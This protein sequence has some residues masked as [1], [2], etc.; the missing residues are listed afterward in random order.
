MAKNPAPFTHAKQVGFNLEDVIL[1]TNNKVALLYPEHSNKELFLCVSDFISKYGEEVSAKGTL[2]KSLLPPR[3]K[4]L[5]AQIIQCLGGKTGGFNQITNK[6]AIILYCLANGFNI[7]YAM[8]LWEDIINK[9]KKKNTEKFVNNWALKPNQTEGPPFIDHMMEICNAE[10]PVAFKAPKPSSNAERVPQGTKPGAKPGHKKHSTSKQPPVSSSEVNKGGSSKAST[11]SKIV[12]L[13]RKKESNS[14]MDSIPSQTSAS[15]PVV[16]EMHKEDLQ[17]TG[18][19]TSLG[20]TSKARANHQLSSGMLAFNLN[21]PIYL[22]SFIIHYESASGNDASEIS[23]AGADLRISAPGIDPHVLADKT[24]SVS[25]GLETVLTTPETGTSNTTKTSEQI[26]FGSIKLED[27]AYLVLNV[28]VDFKDLDSPEDD[29]II[30]SQKHTLETEKRKAKAEITRLKAQ[31]FFPN[32]GQ[33]NEQLVKSLTTK[34][35]KIL[36]AHDFSSSLP[37][38]LK[39]LPSKFDELTEEELPKEFVSLLVQ[40]ASVQAKLQTLDALP[41]ILLNI[42]KALNKFAQVLDSVS[43]KA[44]DQSVPSASQVDTMPA[45]GEKNTN[46]TT[47]SQLFQR[48]SEKENLNNQQPKPTTP[49]PIPPIITTTTHMQSSFLSKPL[50]ISSQLEGEQTKIEKG[51]KVMYS[52]DAE[53]E[54]GEHVHLTKEQISTQKKI[55]EEAKAEAAKREGEIRKEELIDILSPEVV[56]KYYNDKLQYDRYCDKMLNRRAKSRITN[57]DILTRKGEWREV[58]TAYP[59]KKGNGSLTNKRLK[60][61]VQYKD[62]PTGT[63]LNEPIL[64]MI[65]FSSYHRQDLV[66]IEDFRDFSNTMLYTVQEIL[67]R[68]HQGPG[69][70]DHART[71]SSFLLAEIDKRTL[72]PLKQM[73]VIEQLRQ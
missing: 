16:A 1:N 65:L 69:L 58:V 44:R 38:E 47:I 22:T 10:K 67:F 50:E 49:P 2:K 36:F 70:D 24:K 63:M 33:L 15:T 45:K 73:R 46:Q 54:N 26:K 14:A 32:V 72:N 60:S 61:S 42:T 11:G 21:D 17:D 51:K 31:L 56:N 35:S 27:L 7:D 71:F 30:V 3:C 40:V 13:K 12:H 64:G 25:D 18:G 28:K 37:I 62:H 55:E 52:K 53:E 4:P 20:V 41:G 9:L 29:P 23:I 34:F 39:D 5:M 66:T 57:C 59:N 43:S 68:L 19:L 8:I 48:Q 6:D